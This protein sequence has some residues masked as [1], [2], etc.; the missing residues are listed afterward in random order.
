MFLMKLLATSFALGTVVKY[1]S[2]L[3]SLPFTPSTG[4]ALTLVL[5]PPI[6]WSAWALLLKQ[7]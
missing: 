1:G 2:L 3:I 6:L 4:A 7:Q 5:G